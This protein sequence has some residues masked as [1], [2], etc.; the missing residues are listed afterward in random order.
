MKSQKLQTINN[1]Q[2]QF[3]LAAGQGF[4]KPLMAMKQEQTVG[5]LETM[6]TGKDLQNMNK[7]ILVI[8]IELI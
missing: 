3:H 7:I 1:T 5:F 8:K 6:Q 4:T 2:I